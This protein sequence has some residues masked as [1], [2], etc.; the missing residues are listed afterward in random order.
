M[1]YLATLAATL[2]FIVAMAAT[3][4]PSWLEIPAGIVGVLI[5]RHWHWSTRGK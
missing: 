2:I 3:G 5:L 1:R 4:A